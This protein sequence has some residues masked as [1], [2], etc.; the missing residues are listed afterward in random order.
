MRNLTGYW[1]GMLAAGA[2]TLTAACNKTNETGAVTSKANGETSSAPSSDAVESRDHALIRAVNAIPDKS[3]LTIYAGD[4]AAFKNVGYKKTTGYEEIPDNLFNFQLK[5]ANAA[6]G[7]AVAQNRENLHDGGH[8]T[9]VALPSEDPNDEN[10][11]VLDDDLKPGAETSGKARV[12]FI[13]GL[14]GDTDVDLF[15]KGQKD[16]LFDGVNFKAEAGWKD[17][18]PAS[19]TLVVRP[20]N[21]TTTLA[22]LAN[23]QLE[24]SKSYTFVV[25]GKPGKY[26]I[27]KVEDTVAKEPS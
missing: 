16:P 6:N 7:E 3:N 4:S 12:R 19:G 21:K 14:A 17:V 10:L 5:A 20:D 11:R 9:I 26:E 8:Y 15:I 24:A 22:T 18:D 25:V 1:M 2:V 23:Q 27:V 13:N